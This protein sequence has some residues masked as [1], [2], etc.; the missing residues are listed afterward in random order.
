MY[1]KVFRKIFY[2]LITNNMY[3]L[4]E[5]IKIHYILYWYVYMHVCVYM[6]VCDCEN[7]N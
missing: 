4:I 6:S 1:K 2:K 7:L 5:Y 3:H